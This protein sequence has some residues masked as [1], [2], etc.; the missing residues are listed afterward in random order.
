MHRPLITV[1]LFALLALVLVSPASASS[2]LQ[3]GIDDDGLMQFNPTTALTTAAQWQANGV[4]QSRLMLNWTRLAPSPLSTKKPAAFD[5]RNHADPLYNWADLDRGVTALRSKNINVSLMLSTPMPF[6]ASTQP[7]RRN[8][9]YRPSPAAFADFVHAVTTRYKGRIWSY[10]LLNEPN[11]WFWLS[12]QV[13][14]KTKSLSSCQPASPAIYRELFRAG[15]SASKAVDPTTPVWGGALAPAGRTS[16][17]VTKVSLGPLSFLRSMGCVTKTF[18]PDRSSASCRNFAPLTM[19]GVAIHPHTGTRS[20]GSPAAAADSV[21]I[22]TISRLTSTVDRIQS[23][24]R[25]YN[26]SVALSARKKSR[27]N[28]YI[29]EY[30]IQTNPP[31]PLI[32]VTPGKQDDY[33]QQAAYMMWKNPRVKLLSFY[34]WHDEPV[35]VGGLGSGSWQSGMYYA[36]GKIKPSGRSFPHP[37]W[38]DLPKG[39]KSATVWGQVR[40]P[41]GSLAKQATAAATKS[42]TVQVRSGNSASFKDLKTVSPNADGYF[43]F[44]ASVAGTRS[45]RFVYGSPAQS[46]EVRTVTPRRR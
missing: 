10:I 30:G 42:V 43:S 15:Y 22:P 12:P 16:A 45:F 2:S 17:D 36:N 24:G 27:L 25:I 14:C 33:Y 13:S 38:V 9:S 1:A 11:L 3:I 4:R 44:K 29:D 46:S 19:D 35:G 6:W 21:T 32:G 39:S 20:P 18:K 23:R 41:Q 7:A 40:P 37:F 26:G 28:V 34:L 31:E 5:A 8:N